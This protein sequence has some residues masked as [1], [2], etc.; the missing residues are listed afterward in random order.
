VVRNK[1][2]A[3]AL[4]RKVKALRN[5]QTGKLTV[6]GSFQILNSAL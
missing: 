4:Q 5:S 2:L 1:G 3:A 6:K